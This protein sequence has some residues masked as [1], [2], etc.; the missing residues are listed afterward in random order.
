V[1]RL[2]AAI[3]GADDDVV[4]LFAAMAGKAASAHDHQIG[5]VAGLSS[6]LSGKSSTGHTHALGGL[7][8]VTVTGVA[9]G[10]T[11]RYSGG[12]WIAAA[13]GIGDIT[14]LS[15]T[16]ASMQAAIET[17]DDGSY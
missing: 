9:T 11:I 8:D 2:I 3:N 1:N 10:Y 6:A 15:P 12:A 13:L 16:L 14:N 7:S 4:A 5:D 17:M